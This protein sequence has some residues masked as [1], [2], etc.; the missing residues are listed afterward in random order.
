VF[1]ETATLI[2][3]IDEAAD[4]LELLGDLGR[5][6]AYEQMMVLRYSLVNAA[7]SF[8]A[9]TA[10]LVDLHVD[11][12]RPLIMICAEIYGAAEAQERADEIAKANRLRTPGLVPRGTVLRVPQPGAA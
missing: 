2:E 4:E 10:A 9:A 12:P 6:Q 7:A 11:Q 8:T 3:K 1:L 5:W